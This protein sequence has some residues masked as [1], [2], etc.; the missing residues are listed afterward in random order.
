MELA[1]FLCVMSGLD[2]LNCL[3]N[4][5]REDSICGWIDCLY[6]TEPSFLLGLLQCSQIYSNLVFKLTLSLCIIDFSDKLDSV[7]AH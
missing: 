1:C 2:T 6:T 3:L 4:C 5:L 7:D